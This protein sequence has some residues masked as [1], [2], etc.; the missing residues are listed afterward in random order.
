LSNEY[1]RIIKNM[2]Q[3]QS[4]SVEVF[5]KAKALTYEMERGNLLDSD[6]DVLK[7][8]LQ[9]LVDMAESMMLGQQ[10]RVNGYVEIWQEIFDAMGEKYYWF[11]KE[12][13]RVWRF[14]N[15]DA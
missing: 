8:M 3:F 4:N 13:E 9:Y 1:K 2:S 6:N 10:E 7:K 12:E 14:E 11:W 5:R 15:L